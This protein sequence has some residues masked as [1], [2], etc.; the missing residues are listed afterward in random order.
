VTVPIAGVAALMLGWRRRWTELVVL[1]AGLVIAHIAVADIKHALDRP[2]PPDPI[3]AAD[4]PGFPSG[5][6]AYSVLYLWLAITVVVRIS[7]GLAIR[8]VIVAVGFAIAALV[9][10]SRVYLGVHYLSDVTA[11]WALGLSAF[12][13]CAVIALVATHLRQN[14]PRN[15]A[16]GED[17]A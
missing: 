3:D 14:A 17:R 9:G 5:H 16:S 15:V 7:P 11:G 1:V 6:A 4:A 2:R 8:S 10:L 13:L 12:A